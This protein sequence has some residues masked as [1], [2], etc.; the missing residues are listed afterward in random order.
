MPVVI[1][2]GVILI[3]VLVKHEFNRLR[4]LATIKLNAS[5]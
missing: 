3:T 2:L 1:Y 4:R 5:F